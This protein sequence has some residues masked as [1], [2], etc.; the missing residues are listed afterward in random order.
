MTRHPGA[1]P[2]TTTT[3]HRA[4]TCHH[5]H[6]ATSRHPPS[7][8][9]MTTTQRG[10]TSRPHVPPPL[11]RDVPAPLLIPRQRQ[12]Q[13]RCDVVAPHATT[14]TMTTTPPCTPSPSLSRRDARMRTR[15]HCCQRRTIDN[16]ALSP[17]LCIP[18]GTQ[19]MGVGTGVRIPNPS[20]TRHP[21]SSRPPT[22][23]RCSSHTRWLSRQVHGHD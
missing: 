21:A 4:P 17:S 5:H 7:P 9:T 19:S 20:L 23:P 22:V 12:R 16:G 8:T 15:A 6:H 11:R 13:R 14:T 2:C 18:A 3:Q 10:A 1:A